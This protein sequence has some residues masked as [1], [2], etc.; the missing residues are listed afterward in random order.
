MQS[1]SMYE[2]MLTQDEF[3]DWHLSGRLKMQKTSF[4]GRKS[5][6]DR[7]KTNSKSL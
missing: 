4:S 6:Y 7:G 5:E 2:Y 3:K 1:E